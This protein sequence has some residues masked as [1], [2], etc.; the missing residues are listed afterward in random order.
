METIVTKNTYYSRT[1]SGS[2][3]CAIVVLVMLSL[4][5]GCH[6]Q[7]EDVVAP[8]L[9]EEQEALY[10]AIQGFVGNGWN[11]SDLYPDPCGW[12]PIQGV[13]C[14]LFDGFW[15]VS[16]LNIGPVHD[17]S[18]TC[19]KKPE[20]RPE[21]FQLNHL[22]ILSFFNCFTS[23]HHPM[24]LPIYNWEKLSRTLETLEFRS[25]PALIGPIPTSF[26]SLEKLQSLILLENKLTG[27]IPTSVGNLRNLKRLV[28]SGNRF[29]GQVPYSLGDLDQLLIL[30][31]SW[32]SLSGSLPSTFGY[33]NS[34]LKL[35]LS[36]NSIMGQIPYEISN[37][38]NLTILDLRSNSFSGE[39]MI[40]FQKMESLQELVI[41]HNPIGGDL[42]AIEWE[43]M[44]NLVF[45]DLSRCGITGKVPESIVE[46]PK[47]RYLDLSSNN[48]NGGLS[49]KLEK[50]ASVSAIY[51]YGNKLT[52]ELMFTDGFYRKM[53]RKFGAWGNPGLCYSGGLLMGR[54]PVGVRQCQVSKGDSS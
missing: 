15:Y 19:A 54:G 27:Q 11:G 20:F 38:K 44:K 7:G 43:N 14:D 25:N 40:P 48:L 42:D 3:W 22:R 6:G 21:L 29:T 53:G 2:I 26:G 36:F 51:V 32:N 35:D 49:P 50:M 34:L 1:C 46:M 37:L 41:A 31:M 23:T 10:N 9:K 17:N 8:M 24:I 30:D 39:L 52:G 16:E 5:G 4:G 47:V 45:L 28:L 33:L 18:L 13:A 12:T